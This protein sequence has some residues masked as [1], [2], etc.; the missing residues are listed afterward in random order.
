MYDEKEREARMA[1]GEVDFY[2]P[3]PSGSG[4]D[5]AR[6]WEDHLFMD[7]R[8]EGLLVITD[9]DPEQSRHGTFA[10]ARWQPRASGWEDDETLLP[11]AEHVSLYGHRKYL[12]C[13]F[14]FVRG[15]VS[16]TNTL[17]RVG[18]WIRNLG[19]QRNRHS[20]K[21]WGKSWP[22]CPFERCYLGSISLVDNT[23]LNRRPTLCPGC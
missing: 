5:M 12:P 16:C 4:L 2:I 1:N 18:G 23:R 10:V 22:S 13:L 15:S 8:D 6:E 19:V 17:C 11:S 20:S 3:L 7:R 21:G 9:M 14:Q